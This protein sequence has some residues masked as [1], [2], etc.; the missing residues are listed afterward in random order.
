MMQ[1][2]DAKR[3]KLL[4]GMLAFSSSRIASAALMTPPSTEGPFYPTENMRYEDIDNDL[5]KISSQVRQAGGEIVRLGG[6]VLDQ[7]GDPVASARVEIWQCDVNGRY[8]HRGDYDKNRND[9]AF[10]GFGHDI[11]DKDGRYGFRTIKPVRY[12]GRTPHIHLKVWVNGADQLTTQLYLP[13]HPD[14]ERDFLYRRIPQDKRE[15]VTMRFEDTGP[16]P[17]AMV[18]LVV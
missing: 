7:L 13:D 17:E 12:T 2:N 6:R 3:R 18:D 4:L 1:N 16:E 10:Q 5:V 9:A 8:L 14:N 11:T 15:L